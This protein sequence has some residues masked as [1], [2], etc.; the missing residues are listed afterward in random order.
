MILVGGEVVLVP[1]RA[2]E[3][4]IGTARWVR[5]YWL[6]ALRNHVLTP[7]SS[8]KPGYRSAFSDPS[9]RMIVA[10]GNSSSTTTTTGPRNGGTWTEPRSPARPRRET[11]SEVGLKNRNDPMKI[12]FA[13]GEVPS[14]RTA[15]RP[16]SG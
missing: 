8:A 15:G 3:D 9:A 10:A 4:I 7:A 5:L 2:G 14:T 13:A 6:E 11:S 12:R 16:A 1:D